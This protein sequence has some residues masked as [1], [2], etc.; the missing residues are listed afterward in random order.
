[1]AKRFCKNLNSI[2]TKLIKKFDMFDKIL[3]RYWWSCE[4][5]LVV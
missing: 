4:A 3:T 1:M 2:S 5:W